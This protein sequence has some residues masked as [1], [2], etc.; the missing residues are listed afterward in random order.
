[1]FGP[2]YPSNIQEILTV[3]HV[4]TTILSFKN[5]F[6]STGVLSMASPVPDQSPAY[7]GSLVS[8]RLRLSKF[9][10]QK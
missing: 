10:I 6:Q 9:N 2:Y 3:M 5:I 4:L 8:F 1:M 7:L